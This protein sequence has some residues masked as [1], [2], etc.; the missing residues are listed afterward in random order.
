ALVVAVRVSGLQV[1][2][3]AGRDPGSSDLQF[4]D[5]AGEPVL[6]YTD[7][8]VWD[9]KGCPLV[10]RMESVPGGLR[11]EVDA[12]GAAYPVT[13]DPLIASLEA[14]LGP[15][16]TGADAEDDNF[17]TSVSLDGDSAL[18]GVFSDDDQG[19]NGGA[20]YVFVRDALGD[21]SEQAKLTA[22]D[23]AAYDAFGYSVSLEGDTALIGAYGDDDG[24]S[25]R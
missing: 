24:G 7:L 17:G 9:A 19:H 13:I 4:V 12:T 22:A 25:D 5:A 15:E 21:W 3:L 23:G 2:P 6:S 1:E 18:I 8:K 16:V 10:A 11:I 14:K 20:A